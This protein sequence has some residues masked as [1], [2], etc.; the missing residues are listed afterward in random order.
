MPD[1]TTR[2]FKIIN[3]ATFDDYDRR[4]LA[5]LSQADVFIASARAEGKRQGMVFDRPMP[6]EI[7]AAFRRV[8]G[9]RLAELDIEFL[10]GL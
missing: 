3:W 5:M 1:G 2:E 9:S 7:D 8:F 10:S 4:F 6:P